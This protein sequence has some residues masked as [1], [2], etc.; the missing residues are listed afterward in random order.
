MRARSESARARAGA[1]LAT[2]AGLGLV[3]L[4]VRLGG[5]PRG[6]GV[7]DAPAVGGEL[8]LSSIP[9][10]ERSERSALR[11]DALVAGAHPRS[12]SARAQGAAAD[13][14]REHEARWR[15]VLRA[16]GAEPLELAREARAVLLGPSPREEKVGLLRA[17]HAERAPGWPEQ[18]ALAL[19]ELP[20][21]SDPHGESVPEF[22]LS[23][24]GRRAAAEP[25]AR[26]A[27]IEALRAARGR[28]LGAM[29]G[30]GLVR[31]VELAD[32]SELDALASELALE[33]DP[34]VRE[35][36]AAA[37]ADRER[38]SRLALEHGAGYSEF[39]PEDPSNDS[40]RLRRARSDHG[41]RRTEPADRHRTPTQE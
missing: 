1:L 21:A 31:W 17:L 34:L 12:A 3:A 8:S 32:A 20:L 19:R 41:A 6:T 18:F 7:L 30:R 11:P 23:H 35:M 28:D 37:L 39:D 2:A 13:G 38:A 15:S 16:G 25:E 10:A 29:R 5:P 40:W 14:E 26:S 4:A 24:L 22:V 27:L 33:S 36:V 9:D